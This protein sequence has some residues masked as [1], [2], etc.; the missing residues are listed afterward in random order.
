MTIAERKRVQRFIPKP[1]LST[2]D[3]E[4]ARTPNGG[5]TKAQLA[6]WGVL[7][8]PPKGW[9]RKLTAHER[10]TDCPHCYGTGQIQP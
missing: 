5:W 2:A 7:W 6:V 8:P 4:A 10:P 3:I 9:K 1:K